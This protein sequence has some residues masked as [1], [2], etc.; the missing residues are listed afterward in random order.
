M[1]GPKTTALVTGASAGIGAEFARQLAQRCEVIL[2]VGRDAQKLAALAQSLAPAVEVHPLAVDLATL[3]GVTRTIELLRQKGPVDYLINNAGFATL[4][5]FAQGQL[6]DQQ[7]MVDVHI[8]ATLALCRAAIPFMVERGGGAI[9]NVSSMTSFEPIASG[10]VYGA[11]KAFLNHFSEALAQEVSTSGIK[12]QSL[13]PGLTRTEF[14][15]RQAMAGFDT[16]SI[17]AQHWMEA[18]A[19]VAASLAAL[20]GDQVTVVAG[21]NNLVKARQRLGA[22]LQRLAPDPADA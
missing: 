4:G 6:E 11:S 1:K 20:A 17:P 13:C 19:V 16:Q 22:Q 21:E 5:H 2:A 9:V 15:S 3:E 10:A 14:H 12:V 18:E 8:S 7:S